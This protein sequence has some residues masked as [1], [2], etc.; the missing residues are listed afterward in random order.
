MDNGSLGTPDPL[1]FINDAPTT[2]PWSEIIV[3]HS[4]SQDNNADNWKAI[5]L[6]HRS[7][8]VNYDIFTSP[9][10]LSLLPTDDP[11]AG[12]KFVEFNGNYYVRQNVMDFYKTVN[13]KGG[14]QFPFLSFINQ[15]IN[16]VQVSTADSHIAYN[17]G[18][19]LFNGKYVFKQGR[20]FTI[21]GAHCIG[22]NRTGIGVCCV[23]NFDVVV[24]SATQYFLMSCL[25]RRLMDKFN[26]PITNIHPHREFANKTCPGKHFSM[27]VLLKYITGEI[28]QGGSNNDSPN[29]GV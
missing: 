20:P 29:D 3:H 1:M 10:D 7:F 28:T 15:E 5:D 19:E 21:A 22:H 24:P 26:I 17:A 2:H 18:L 8:R 4:E 12:G 13:S 11:T 25:I 16:G 14:Q 23:S 9:V 27:D 6:Y